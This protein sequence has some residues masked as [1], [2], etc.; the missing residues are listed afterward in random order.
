MKI[1]FWRTL[2]RPKEYLDAT[3]II[4][5]INSNITEYKSLIFKSTLFNSYLTFFPLKFFTLFLPFIICY[6]IQPLT[7]YA[8]RLRSKN[9]IPRLT[10]PPN[11]QS[12][13]LPS[14]SPSLLIRLST[15]KLQTVYA[16]RVHRMRTQTQENEREKDCPSTFSVV[17]VN[18]VADQRGECSNRKWMENLL[19]K[20]KLLLWYSAGSAKTDRK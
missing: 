20:H 6:I 11:P 1:V 13:L 7:I 2:S 4:F 19:S 15:A 9:Q 3:Y 12:P 8:P 14:S 5:E 18:L 10:H 17:G 16:T